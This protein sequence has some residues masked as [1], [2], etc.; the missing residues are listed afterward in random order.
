MGRRVDGGV[1]KSGGGNWGNPLSNYALCM[2]ASRERYEIE[3]KG[4]GREGKGLTD[5]KWEF[6]WASTD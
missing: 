3:R 1:G 4:Q 2:P 6:K 5:S